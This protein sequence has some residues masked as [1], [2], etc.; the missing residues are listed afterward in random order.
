MR[1]LTNHEAGA[2][3]GSRTS[4]MGDSLSHESAIK[5]VTGSALYVDDIPEPVDLLHVATGQSTIAHGRI[6]SLNLDAVRAAKGVVDVITISDVP[7]DP[8][9]SPVYTGDL[10]L[11]SK[12]VIY[13]GQPIFAVAATSMEL[14]RRACQ[15][16]EIEYE[17]LDAVLTPQQALA[18]ESFVLPT[19]SFVK[20]DVDAALGS[21]AHIIEAEQ[22]VRGQEHF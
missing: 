18:D 16:A 19:R 1:K 3:L 17:V 9:V 21:A 12:E 14:A 4:G 22:Y 11:A 20:G 15:L 5:H 10:L 6:K 13:V 2:E 7:G 8:D